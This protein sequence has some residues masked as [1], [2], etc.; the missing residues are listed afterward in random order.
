M[1]GDTVRL[2]SGGAALGIYGLAGLS[3]VAAPVYTGTDAAAPASD[4]AVNQ[5]QEIIVTA[6]R[7]EVAISKVPISVEAFSKAQMDNLGVRDLSDIARLTPG[8]NFAQTGIRN[9]NDL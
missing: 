4:E 8:L 6:T 7:S 2:I 9:G 1:V 5:V 3:A